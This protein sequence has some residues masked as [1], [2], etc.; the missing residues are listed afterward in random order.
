[1][2][3]RR[4]ENTT[5]S[6]SW[7]WKESS[8]NILDPL[9]WLS[10]LNYVRNSCTCLLKIERWWQCSRHWSPASQSFAASECATFHYHFQPQL[11]YDVVWTAV[12]HGPFHLRTYREHL[13]GATLVEPYQA[14]SRVQHEGE[15]D[16][17]IART[18]TPVSIPR[19]SLPSQHSLIRCIEH[20]DGK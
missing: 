9:S 11:S 3:F 6:V 13:S 2:F 19:E 15:F 14:I 20:K 5:K 18:L 8:K 1:M 12:L 17:A 4:L 16:S 7:P 10:F